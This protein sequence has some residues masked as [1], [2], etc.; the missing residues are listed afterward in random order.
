MP[1]VYCV[2][3]AVELAARG[4]EVQVAVP[5]VLSLKLTRPT[6]A[7]QR[8]APVSRFTKVMLAFRMSPGYWSFWLAMY[9]IS[10]LGTAVMSLM[11]AASVTLA[12]VLLIEPVDASSAPV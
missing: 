2:P 4:V 1:M 7:V 11:V 3:P 5:T 12:L 6:D 8:T 10:V 9:V